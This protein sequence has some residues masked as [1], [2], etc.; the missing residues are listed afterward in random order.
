MGREAHFLLL[1]TL[2]EYDFSLIPNLSKPKVL[3][4][5]RGDFISQ[6]DE[7]TRAG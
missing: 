6:A 3:E 4:L 7:M 2:D 1:R 5:A